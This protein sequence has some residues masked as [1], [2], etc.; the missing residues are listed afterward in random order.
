MIKMSAVID[1]GKKA[2]SGL[3]ST[4]RVDLRRMIDIDTETADRG[5]FN[6]PTFGVISN[7]GSLV[8][9]DSY[10]NEQW[11][12]ESYANANALIEGI[13][14]SVYIENS[15]TK[16]KRL[17]DKYISST[18]DY[19]NDNHSV[20]VNFDDTLK[21]WQDITIGGIDYDPRT[22]TPK[23]LEYFYKYL[24]NRTSERGFVMK[25]FDKLDAVTRDVL[26]RITVVY[27]LLDSANLWAQW[28]KLCLASQSHIFTRG[29]EIDF[30]YN[31]GN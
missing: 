20:T 10:E 23:T 5:D 11:V 27:P 13:E 6:L 3:P 16:V 1:F 9:N 24:H 17:V 18:W 4:I 30:V 8:F 7:G 26:S 21:K 15:L 25:P 29:G 14:I 28:N 2:I 22:S 12:I 31:G 19:D